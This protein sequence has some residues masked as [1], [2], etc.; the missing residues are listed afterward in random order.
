MDAEI[1]KLKGIACDCRIDMLK[2][3]ATAESGHTAA[4]MGIMDFL[5]AMYFKIL[6][7]DPK[8]PQKSDRDRFVLSCG[9]YAP[10]LYAVMAHRGFF[11]IK[12]LLTLRDLNSRL[13]GHPHN[14]ALPGIENTS[15]PLGQG[16]SQAVGM[17]LAA[18]IDQ[19][20]HHIYCLTSD[21][22]T[23]EGQ[24]WEALMLAPARELDNLTCFVDRNFIQIDGNTEDVVP[25]EPLAKKYQAFGWHT[26]E[27]DGHNFNQIIDGCLQAKSTHLPTMIILNTIPG[28]AVKEIENDFTWHGKPPTPEE[29]ER[30]I[31]ELK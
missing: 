5:V 3:L 7:I 27:I 22:E 20:K 10:A 26:I 1:A 15:G 29:A 17:A 8:N 30:F 31:K 12:E 25:L 14:L 24:V 21:G 9:H 4:P 19:K 18:K 2:A 23:Q 6:N 11:P 28:K 13:Q 16:I